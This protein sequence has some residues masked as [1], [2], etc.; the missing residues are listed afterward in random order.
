MLLAITHVKDQS[1]MG[2]YGWKVGCYSAPHTKYLHHPKAACSFSSVNAFHDNETRQNRDGK[3]QQAPGTLLT[4]SLALPG[5]PL[6]SEM[7]LQGVWM[8]S[9]SCLV[10]GSREQ[11]SH[12]K[13]VT[14]SSL[15][16][17][18]MVRVDK[19]LFL[20]LNPAEIYAHAEFYGG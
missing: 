4:Q 7:S 10:A 9:K 16:V 6:L 2:C 3:Q 19:L 12:H 15:Y 1:S 8:G 20:A 17:W 13:L 14:H 18:F 5:V 11:A